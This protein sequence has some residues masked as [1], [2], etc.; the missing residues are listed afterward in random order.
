MFNV[1]VVGK[2]LLIKFRH[3]PDPGYRSDAGMMKLPQNGS[4]AGRNTKHSM[5]NT[6]KVFVA[7][8]SL[9][10]WEIPSNFAEAGVDKKRFL[11]VADLADLGLVSMCLSGC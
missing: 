5:K 7:G 4:D 6:G 8:K 3:S 2:F 11:N 1:Y 10:M 9:K